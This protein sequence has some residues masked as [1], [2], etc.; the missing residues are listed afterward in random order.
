MLNDFTVQITYK[1][2]TLDDV[3]SRTCS[4]TDYCQELRTKIMHTIMD[5]ENI[6]YESQQ[7]KSKEEWDLDAM[8]DFQKIRHKMLDAAN[9]VERLPMNLQYKGTSVNSVK[10]AEFVAETINKLTEQGVVR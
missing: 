6:F 3:S 10:A 8:R 1:N 2:K 4:L 5:V 9:A 7:N